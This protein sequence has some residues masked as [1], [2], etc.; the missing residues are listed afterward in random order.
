MPSNVLL[1]MHSKND[2]MLH[3][4]YLIEGILLDLSF[5]SEKGKNDFVSTKELLVMGACVQISNTYLKS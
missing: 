2:L 4:H 3:S 5:I 1:S